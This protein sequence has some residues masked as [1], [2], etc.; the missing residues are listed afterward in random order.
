M[1]AFQSLLPSNDSEYLD[2]CKGL[3][4]IKK[5]IHDLLWKFLR[6][7]LKRE[8]TLQVL[9]IRKKNIFRAFHLVFWFQAVGELTTYHSEVGSIIIDTIVLIDLETS[10]LVNEKER[11][12]VK[13][14]FLSLLKESEKYLCA[15]TLKERM[16]IE[17]L[18]NASIVKNSKKFFSTVIKTKTKLL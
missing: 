14:R 10:M 4:A 11:E 9:Y 16:E 8:Q 18:G 2:D 15:D 13:G 5:N 3:T 1:K 6:G 12:E 17:T 7:H